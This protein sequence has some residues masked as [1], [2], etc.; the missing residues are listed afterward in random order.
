MCR[1]LEASKSGYYAWL[2]LSPTPQQQRREEL[3]EMIR[4]IHL[5]CRSVYGARRIRQELL[6]LGQRVTRKT[7]VR[8]MKHADIAA[9]RKKRFKKTTDSNHR[10]PLAD[11]VLNR[12]FH[13]T[14]PNECWVSDITY[15][16]TG[17]GWLYLATFID[18][19]SRSI[20]GWSMSDM[21]DGGFVVEAFNMG[22][23]RRSTAPRMVHSDRG[24]QYASEAL[25]DELKKHP[26]ARSMSR[27]ANC[28]D[29]AVAESFF[30]SLKGELVYLEKFGSREEARLRVFE[31]IEVFYNRE[32]LHSYLN[33][34]S[35]AEF[36]RAHMADSSQSSV[37]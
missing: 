26:C 21:L 25:L 35:P 14:R 10:L 3:I 34:M 33:Y 22:C 6:R 23:R 8:L 32:R 16:R 5:R 27:T 13:T 36:E 11:N 19:F 17:E 28:Y 7:V 30:A 37:R 4:S 9:K 2:K 12:E 20:V 29:N 31:Y 24:S 18:L 1:V 15:I